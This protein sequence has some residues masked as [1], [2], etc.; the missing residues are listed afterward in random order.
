MAASAVGKLTQLGAFRKPLAE[1]TVPINRRCEGDGH[2]V[3][4]VLVFAVLMAHVS[5]Q[6]QS[7]V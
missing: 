3:A 4:I 6:L 5:Y 2:P 1:L 7:I